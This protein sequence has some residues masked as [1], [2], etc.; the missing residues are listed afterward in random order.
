MGRSDCGRRTYTSG[1][2]AAVSVMA[3]TKG[4]GA[5][6]LSVPCASIFSVSTGM[7]GMLGI[8]VVRLSAA[9]C[10]ACG[11]GVGAARGAGAGGGVNPNPAMAEGPPPKIKTT[12]KAVPLIACAK[13]F[14][15]VIAL[16][17]CRSC[18]APMIFEC[19]E[20]RVPNYRRLRKIT[21]WKA[22]LSPHFFRQHLC[23][24][25]NFNQNRPCACGDRISIPAAFAPKASA[26]TS[27]RTPETS[28][29]AV[30]AG[31]RRS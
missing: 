15:L 23:Q 21:R 18:A 20:L 8:S 11:G 22:L 9:G 26:E 28:I 12:I 10:C 4:S 29:P 16:P 19:L 27:A 3:E 1:L 31:Q 5:A 7:V 17:F 13:T 14:P 30:P 24:K 6:P 2:E 25:P